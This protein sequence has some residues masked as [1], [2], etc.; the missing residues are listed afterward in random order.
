MRLEQLVMINANQT[1]SLHAGQDG[2]GKRLNLVA[3]LKNSFEKMSL[4]KRMLISSG[5]VLLVFLGGSG[6]LLNT[7]F[8]ISLDSIVREKLTLHT[9]QLIS[10]GDS[11]AGLMQLPEQLAEPRFNKPQGTMI[12]F[13]TEL[14][15]DNQQQEVWRSLSA[16]DKQFSFPAPESGEWFF[17]RAQGA[18]DAQYYVASYNTTWSNDQGAKTKYIFT[19]MEEFS[20][21]QSQLSKYR[22]A[23]VI[24]LLVFGSIFLLLQTIILRFGL[25]PVR[26]ITADVEAMNKGEIDTLNRQYPKELKPLTTNLNLLIDNE[27]HQRERYR[28]RMA[29]LSHSL[30]T[31][32]SVL[33][34]I[35]SDIDSQ[36]QPISRQNVIDTLSKHVV[37][38][39][40]IV[41]YQ[42][43]RA[44]SNGAPTVFTAIDVAE[45]AKDI[46]LA[47]D[48][49]YA[50]KNI[51][52]E[53]HIENG[54]SFYGDEN[55]LIE[56]MGN[57]LDNAYKH[58]QLSVRLTASKVVSSKGYPQ[59]V[60]TFEDDGC[61]VPS[62]KRQTILQRGVRL[63]SSGEGQGFGLSIVADIVNSYQ[64]VIAIDSSTLG[65]AMFNITIP[66]RGI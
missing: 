22:L 9:Y 36:G 6:L 28:N 52:I 11:D 25:S 61:G 14:A 20:Y 4:A 59:L 19:V 29:D 48:K 41:D 34:G 38:M 62:A 66:T 57:L 37:R 60:L 50:N 45:K 51:T 10:I 8:A 33:R 53:S 13:V 39:T 27:R 63:D 32:L 49:V 17:G 24:G 55:D 21:Y 3:A 15:P 58:G 26:R 2:V 47:L 43:Q 12:A 35:E 40:E 56:I 5:L 1:G 31:P 46:I 64:G 54:L 23:I 30:K 7:I 16:T 65:G 18:N 42:L 44:I